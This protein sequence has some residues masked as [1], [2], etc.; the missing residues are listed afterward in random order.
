[1][2]EPESVKVDIFG[3][4]YTLKGDADPDYVQKVAAFVNERMNEV[5]GNSSVA[6]TAKVAILAAVNIADELFREQ[7]KRLE[8]LAT[9]EDKSDQI[10]HLLAK[11]VGMAASRKEKGDSLPG[12]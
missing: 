6:S 9:L 10:T 12:T 1:M 4:T 7:Q 8:A 2:L 11:E 5:A 3:K